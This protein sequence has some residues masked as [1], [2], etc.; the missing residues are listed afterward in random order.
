MG[1]HRWSTVD[2][3]ATVALSGTPAL[4]ATSS[5]GSV[6]VV[7]AA[8]HYRGKWYWEYSPS[9]VT[10]SFTGCGIA[11][12]NYFDRNGRTTS[13]VGYIY[14]GNSGL[15]GPAGN[16]SFPGSSTGQKVCVALDLD[17]MRVWFR[18]NG[19]NWNSSGLADP[20][21]N[22]G[23]YDISAFGYGGVWPVNIFG[24]SGSVITTNFGDSSFAFTAPSGFLGLDDNAAEAQLDR[25]TL[26]S[27]SGGTSGPFTL[28][29]STQHANE[30]IVVQSFDVLNETQTIS[31]TAGLT[32]HVRES[33]L[34]ITVNGNT[35]Y[36][37]SWWALAPTPLTGDV[38]TFTKSGGFSQVSWSVAGFKNVDNTV[39]FD[40]NANAYKQT[41][42]LA[43]NVSVGSIASNCTEGFLVGFCNE[44][45]AQ[46]T[47]PSPT[48]LNG[49][50]ASQGNI[51][52]FNRSLHP[53]KSGALSSYTFTANTTG[54]GTQDWIAV[55]EVLALASG[56][57]QL[58]ANIADDT[59]LAA[60]IFVD[61]AANFSDTNGLSATLD[62]VPDLFS[63]TFTDDNGL[64]AVFGSGGRDLGANFAD[65]NGVTAT[66]DVRNA[67]DLLAIIKDDFGFSATFT[68]TAPA[69]PPVQVV[70]FCVC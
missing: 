19:G 33:N 9:T 66:L 48:G 27:A 50:I 68:H 54:G 59:G 52:N 34:P 35:R 15:Y 64:T 67:G 10:D 47:A 40:P 6:G 26:A 45:N 16:I 58:T 7:G 41:T 13:P 29:I 17:N 53:F 24:G 32:W 55:T 42:G 23:G 70:V 22:V 65:D 5:A 12:A 61:W 11:F 56:A 2:K 8:P 62:P 51:A 60:T 14:Y 37:R 46:S 18:L 21:T 3:D 38:I 44:P 57:A 30:V 49:S 31:D 20:A 4:T 69:H 63:A 28:T 36:Y 43:S 1:F 39:P 25:M